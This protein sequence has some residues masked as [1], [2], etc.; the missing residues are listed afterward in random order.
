LA[1]RSPNL[2]HRK[3]AFGF[4]HS[5]LALILTLLLV[6]AFASKSSKS[7]KKKPTTKKL[8]RVEQVKRDQTR[9][10]RD[11][12]SSLQERIADFPTE[13]VKGRKIVIDPG[14]TNCSPGA[15]GPKRLIIEADL[16]WG[17]A[18]ALAKLLNDAGAKAILT[19]TYG[20]PKPLEERHMDADLD[21][22]ADVSNREQADLFVSVHH[23]WTDDP[24]INRTEVYYK[25]DDAG[26]SRDAANYIMIHLSR[27]LGLEAN[28]LSANYR[29]LRVNTRPALLTEA[30]YM[31]NPIQE[32]LLADPDKQKLEAQAIY[33]GVIDYFAH[34]VPEFRLLASPADIAPFPHPQLKVRVSDRFGIDRSTVK[35]S[36]DGQPAKVDYLPGDST[37]VI[38][39]TQSMANGAHTFRLAGRNIK[40]NS[41]IPLAI[42]FA[43][44]REPS[45]ISLTVS[46]RVCPPGDVRAEVSA[47]VLDEDG[48]PVADTRRVSFVINKLPAGDSSLTDGS[49]RIY[50]SRNGPGQVPVTARCGRATA[51]TQVTFAATRTPAI[52][53]L[54]MRTGTRTPVQARV[55]DDWREDIVPANRDGIVTLQPAVGTHTFTFSAPGFRR[56]VVSLALAES[57]AERQEIELEPLLSGALIGARI[58]LDPAGNYDNPDT[59]HER[60]DFNLLLADRLADALRDCGAQ[61]QVSRRPHQYVTRTE[62]LER[63]G[64]FKP[65]YYLKLSS[66]SSRPAVGKKPVTRVGHY[67]GSERGAGLA[68]A[69]TT[70]LGA[71]A[72]VATPETVEDRSYEVTNAPCPAT[73]VYLR[74]ADTLSASPDDTLFQNDICRQLLLGLAVQEGA[75]LACPMK[76]RV[77]DAQGKPVRKA[78]ITIDNLLKYR[79]DPWGEVSL[80]GLDAGTHNVQVEAPGFQPA[81]SSMEL[82]SGTPALT[83]VFTLTANR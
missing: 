68:L 1:R 40:G 62:R 43:T 46:P 72:G 29:V 76:F 70:Q 81:N 22:R 37:L 49:A 15:E 60:T 52:Q 20:P 16:N 8:S 35:A 53:F 11:W 51:S 73:A 4:R 63:A 6:P 67:P 59:S 24:A 79:V 9:I 64:G 75:A 78:W 54:V 80:P 38:K 66:P 34:G 71:L 58:L 47:L 65:D 21:Q 3:P 13:P 55:K 32:S 61:V 69:V 44:D 7:S 36:F 50:L 31:S 27:D 45:R 10:A 39:P 48:Q 83:K 18:S 41:G 25:L 17:V 30:S 14:H 42:A 82:K 74:F 33:L 5:V 12:Y 26:P 56:H 28:L 77:N 2:I 23:N 57:D 19:K